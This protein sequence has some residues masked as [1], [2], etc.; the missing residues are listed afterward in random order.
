LHNLQQDT[1]LKCMAAMLQ[2][3]TSCCA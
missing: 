1:H 3:S 2:C